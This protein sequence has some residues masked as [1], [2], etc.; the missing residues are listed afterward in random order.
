MKILPYLFLLIPLWFPSCKENDKG[1]IQLVE[2]G[3]TKNRTP[4]NKGFGLAQYYLL[5]LNNDSVYIQSKIGTDD[6]T[7]VEAW[8]GKIDGLSKNVS[9]IDFKNNSNSTESGT[10]EKLFPSS[11]SLSEGLLSYIS[12]EDGTTEKF[13]YFKTYN[14]NN[15]FSKTI[16]FILGLKEHNQLNKVKAKIKDDSIINPIVNNK[17]FVFV[18]APPPP[19]EP[20]PPTMQE[21]LKIYGQK[22]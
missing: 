9:I 14:P 22:K 7:R 6:S 5:N 18:D 15:Q 13:Y 17:K 20:A 3:L 1:K 8:A 12:F 10:I 21:L 16:Y 11:G 2:L 19:T 4:Q